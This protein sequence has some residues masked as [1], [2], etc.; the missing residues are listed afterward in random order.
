MQLHP[1]KL[2]EHFN[3]DI[4]QLTNPTTEREALEFASKLPNLAYMKSKTLVLPTLSTN[5]VQ[6]SPPSQQQQHQQAK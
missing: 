2:S 1:Q 5:T 6:S 3:L 4:M